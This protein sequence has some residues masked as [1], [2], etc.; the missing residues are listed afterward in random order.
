LTDQE[1]KDAA[2]AARQLLVHVS[3]CDGLA[4]LSER[5][6]QKQIDTLSDAFMAARNAGVPLL[7]WAQT[8]RGR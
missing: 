7:E 5:F 4:I 2:L 1:S 8:I 3:N 6:D